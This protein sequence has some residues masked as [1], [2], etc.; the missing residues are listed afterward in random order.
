LGLKSDENERVKKKSADAAG[1]GPRRQ[2][3]RE[4]DDAASPFSKPFL[5]LPSI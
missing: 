1:G 4:G 3:G 2:K 5:S